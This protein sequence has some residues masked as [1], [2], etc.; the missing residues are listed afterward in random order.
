[1][2]AMQVA[3]SP[4]PDEDTAAA[5]LAAIACAIT[6]DSAL[7]AADVPARASWRVAGVLAAQGL[8]AA[9]N[10]AYAAW[11]AAERARRAERWSSGVVGL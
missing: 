8:P 11:H 6:Q 10:A 7:S 2:R 3:L 9:R 5:V 4:A 1:M